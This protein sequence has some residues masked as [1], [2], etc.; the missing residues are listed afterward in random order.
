MASHIFSSI[1]CGR[2]HDESSEGKS[3]ANKS[4]ARAIEVLRARDPE[5]AGHS[6]SRAAL[7]SEP[8]E[9]DEEPNL[10]LSSAKEV[11]RVATLAVGRAPTLG[12]AYRVRCMKTEVASHLPQTSFSS[13]HI[14]SKSVH[15]APLPVHSEVEADDLRRVEQLEA[16]VQGLQKECRKY[17]K[18]GKTAFTRPQN[19]YFAALP[20]QEPAGNSWSC[21]WNRWYRG[22]LTY[23]KDNR[24]YLKQEE[25]KGSVSLLSIVKVTWDKESPE[26]VIVR[27]MEDGDRYEMV[28][29]FNSKSE[30][31]DWA[32]MLKAVRKMLEEGHS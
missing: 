24:S 5:Q 6:R 9:A 4:R 19:R 23:W 28:L 25:P 15:M 18:S 32:N 14:P 13:P 2:V 21:R 8:A 11:S 17:P 10:R 12:D 3:E 26:E 20:A 30:A 22:K 29:R 7:I 31:K 27:N 1:C 16:L